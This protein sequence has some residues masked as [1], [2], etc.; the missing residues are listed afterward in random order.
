MAV[1]KTKTQKKNALQAI[2]DKAFRLFGDDCL[3][4][5]EYQAIRDSVRKAFNR[6]K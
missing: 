1:Y 3:T 2:Q 4:L 6:I 5:K